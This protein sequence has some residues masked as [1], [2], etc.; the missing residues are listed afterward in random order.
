[1]PKCLA[2]LWGVVKD[3]ALTASEKL[4]L[5]V[6]M[7]GIFALDLLG[8]QSSTDT[9]LLEEDIRTLVEERTEARKNRNFARADEIRDTLAE[10][11]IILEDTPEGTRWKKL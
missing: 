3:D 2:D 9:S 4:D 11:G 6:R 1:M 7:D 5:V 8:A 10:R